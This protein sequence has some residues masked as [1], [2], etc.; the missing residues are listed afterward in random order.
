[1]SSGRLVVEPGRFSCEFPSVLGRKP[2]DPPL[3]HAGRTVV[4][5]RYRLPILLAPATVTVEGEDARVEASLFFR[6]PKLR[7]ALTDAGFEVVDRRAWLGWPGRGRG[8][9]SSFPILAMVVVLAGA[10]LAAGSHFGW[11]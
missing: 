11:F 4:M 7:K 9:R 3:I 8:P 1:M 6:L 2:D 10:L 5:T